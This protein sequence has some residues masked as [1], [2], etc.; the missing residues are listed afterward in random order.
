MNY[1]IAVDGE[2][3]LMY[4]MDMPPSK[5]FCDDLKDA[6]VFDNYNACVHTINRLKDKPGD[7]Y[8]IIPI[9]IK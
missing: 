6:Q 7:R 5:G 3:G 1:V 8:L 2:L 9:Y 4:I